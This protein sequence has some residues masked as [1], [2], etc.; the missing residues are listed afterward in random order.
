V[1]TA[2]AAD[3][4]VL[5]LLHAEL[6][7][8]RYQDVQSRQCVA[9][10]YLPLVHFTAARVAALDLLPPRHPLR[11]ELLACLLHVLQDI[12][13]ALLRAL[14]RSVSQRFLRAFGKRAVAAAAAAAAA[15][16][17]STTGTTTAAAATAS[18]A[19][20]ATATTTATGEPAV[21]VMGTSGVRSLI[22]AHALV[23]PPEHSAVGSP[24]PIDDVSVMRIL[25]LLVS[26][27]TQS[28]SHLRSITVVLTACK[29]WYALQRSCCLTLVS[30]QRSA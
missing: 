27:H 7:I 2:F 15:T 18:T 10:M 26:L 4:T 20:K 28:L 21:G 3:T 23:P 29:G 11:R 16:A 17:A 30:S 5:L 14:W 8:H 25:G 24:P 1:L 6:S 22:N 19:G 13:E 12:P 9:A